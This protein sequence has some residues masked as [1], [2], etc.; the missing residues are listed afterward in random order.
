VYRMFFLG[1]NFVFSLIWTLISK[2]TLKN[3]KTYNLFLKNL[4]FFPAL[5]V[6]NRI[7]MKFYRIVLQ[8]SSDVHRLKESNF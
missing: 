5:V 4:G 2:I 1:G 6:S 8:L 3:L 7:G